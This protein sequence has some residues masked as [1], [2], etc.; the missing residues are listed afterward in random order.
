MN[1]EELARRVRRIAPTARLRPADGDAWRIVT[2]EGVEL[3]R[4]SHS[5]EAWALAFAAVRTSSA[6]VVE[7]RVPAD[8][9]LVAGLDVGQTRDVSAE[10]EVQVDERGRFRVLSAGRLY[11]VSPPQPLK[12]PRL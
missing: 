8:H 5:R 6:A 10:V 1:L 11:P 2:A 9:P 3:G 7:A 12:G 4:A